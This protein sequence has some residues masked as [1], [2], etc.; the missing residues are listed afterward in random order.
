M[1]RSTA[2]R[3]SAPVSVSNA[4]RSVGVLCEALEAGGRRSST[5]GVQLPPLGAPESDGVTDHRVVVADRETPPARCEGEGEHRAGGGGGGAT[6]VNDRRRNREGA[7]R[8]VGVRT[9][10][11]ERPTGGT[12]DRAGRDGAVAPVNRGRGEVGHG[13]ARVGVGE[14]GGGATERLGE[15]P[16]SYTHLRA[17]E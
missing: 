4:A 2:P 1:W 9:A 6:V 7:G 15:V 16:V 11:C 10:H 5:E 8:E 13:R 17:H 3:V 14:R 12:G